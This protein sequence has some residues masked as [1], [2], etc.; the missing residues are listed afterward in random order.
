MLE[1]EVSFQ[2]EEVVCRDRDCG[3]T[4]IHTAGE[5]KWMRDKWGPDYKRPGYC[6]DCRN[7]RRKEKEEREREDRERR[8][9]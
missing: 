9:A 8:E 7:R 1:E 5:Q 2:D 6:K 3:E 4:F